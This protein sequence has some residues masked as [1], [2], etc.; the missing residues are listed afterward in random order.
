MITQNKETQA[1][2]TPAGA[3]AMLVEGNRRFLERKV[4]VRDLL[5]QVELT[6][7]GQ[8]PF[9]VV[10]S[11]IDSRVPAEM[12][13]DQGI[14]DIFSARIAGNFVNEDLLGSMEFATKLAGA[15][16]VLVLGHSA[17]GAVK[18][19][20]DG[21]E[22]GHLTSMLAKIQPAVDAVT[23]PVDTAARTS[24]NGDF[25]QAVVEKNVELTVQAIRDRSEIMRD[26]EAAGDIAIAGA[27][28]DVATGAV[29]FCG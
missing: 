8:A 27:V 7:G 12:V 3:R 25:V 2:L 5:Q 29:T 14:G 6:A 24:A 9:A 13:F 17:C 18:G 16:L 28:Y 11:C 23:E 10:L 19:A 22:L 20:C 1:Q 4:E 21:A 26:L 15:K